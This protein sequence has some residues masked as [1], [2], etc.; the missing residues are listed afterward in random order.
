MICC[1]K[2]KKKNK[3]S[4]LEKS[5][6]ECN[7]VIEVVILIVLLPHFSIRK[8]NHFKLYNSNIAAHL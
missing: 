2:W 3:I 5:Q 6:I 1:L 4:C 8:I 7:I